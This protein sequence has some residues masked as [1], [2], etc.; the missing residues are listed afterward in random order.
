MCSTSPARLD[1]AGQFALQR[2]LAEADS[3]QTK[4]AHIPTRAAA[5]FAA[6]ADTHL[7]FAPTFFN[8]PLI[9]W[10][11]HCPFWLAFIA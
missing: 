3:T 10:P 2:F 9:F 5:K 6:V 11:Q 1:D 7:E 8:N 4:T